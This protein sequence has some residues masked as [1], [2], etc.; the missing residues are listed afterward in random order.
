[1]Q[2]ANLVLELRD[3]QVIGGS[4]LLDPLGDFRS[5]G[6]DGAANHLDIVAG[7][8]LIQTVQFP[9]KAGLEIDFAFVD[10]DSEG[11]NRGG[12]GLHLP[13]KPFDL[14]ACLIVILP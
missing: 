12:G 2:Q 7:G 8:A 13:A 1:M 4:H 11:F 9:F 10:G 14:L 3:G 5:G 6:A